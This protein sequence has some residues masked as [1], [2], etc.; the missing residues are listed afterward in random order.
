[1]GSD[2]YVEISQVHQVFGSGANRYYALADVSLNV[3]EGEFVTLIGHSGCGK[4][5]LMNLVAGFERPTQGAVVVAGKEVTGPGLDRAVVFQSHG[6]LPWLSAL[7]NVKLAVDAVAPEQPDEE[8]RVMALQWVEKVGLR[9][10]YDKMPN[11]LSGGMKQRVGLARAFATQPKVLLMDEPF[12]ALDALT[13]GT[14]QDELLELWEQER[15]TVMM[16]THDVDEAIFLSDRIV[17]MSNGPQA[18][19]AKVLK[20]EIPRPRTRESAIEHPAYAPLRKEL[21]RF[22]IEHAHGLKAA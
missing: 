12:G 11:E 6:L 8:R 2:R 1:M 7:D 10:H 21:L 19:V 22:L 17:L 5:T 16:I 9:R 18:H 15:R 20:V 4:S 3:K 13:R 14:M